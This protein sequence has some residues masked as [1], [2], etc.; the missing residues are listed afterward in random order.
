MTRGNR[1]GFKKAFPFNLGILC[2][3]LILMVLCVVFCSLLSELIPQIRLPMVIVG[4]GYM[5]Y[6]AWKTLRSSS[7]L[8]EK[9]VKG[10]F[11]S[12]LLLQ[13]I[14]PKLYLYA[15][16]SLETYILPYYENNPAA[17]YS[18]A[19]LLAV[20]GFLSTLCWSGFGSAFKWLFSTHAKKV[21]AIMA[22]LLVYCAVSLFFA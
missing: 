19:V 10:G 4:A 13:F 2:G 17:L 21:N 1:K 20:I 7:P 12:G 6:L 8:E 9:D 18:F 22:L 14:N 15:I 16:V 11:L 5:L 3:F